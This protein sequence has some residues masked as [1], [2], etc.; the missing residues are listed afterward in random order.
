MPIA[1]RYRA[2][3]AATFAAL[4]QRREL[5]G[6]RLEP[7]PPAELRDRYVDTPDGALL[8]DGFLL[9]LRRSGTTLT[10]S[11]RVG[12]GDDYEEVERAAL[13][14]AKPLALP[15]GALRDA[16]M[17]RTE[18]RELVDLLRFRQYRTPRALYLGDRLVG[19]L[20][21]DVVTDETEA[22]APDTAPDTAHEVQT[23]AAGG[24]FPEDRD[25]LAAALD[26][27]G[28][29]AEDT[30]KVSTALVRRGTLPSG[31]LLLLP[32]ERRALA[33]LR[34]AEATVERRRAEVVLLAADGLEA[35]A[36]S[37]RVGLAPS[38]VRHWLDTFASERLGAFPSVLLQRG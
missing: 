23:E 30:P 27:L 11:L 21:L 15:P 31:A 28:L 16:V 5:A 25:R 19:V 38:R 14:P 9:R 6:F 8:A 37:R 17:K 32:A 29:V 10:A 12:E 13:D 1:R 26:V 33:T 24:T 20:S 3:D 34:D 4:L 2:P 35:A 22:A 7:A 36:V 18:D